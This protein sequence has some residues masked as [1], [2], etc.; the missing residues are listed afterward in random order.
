MSAP[1]VAALVLSYNGREVTLEALASLTRMDYPAYDVW[2]VDN[3]S[4]DGTAAAVAAAFPALRQLRIARNRGPA[5]G[6]AV[7]MHAA[8]AAG[9]DYVLVLNN[10]IEVAPDLLTEM[11]AA[12]E[13]EP[14]VG[15]VGPK[16]YYYWERETIWSAGG[17]LRFAEAITSEVGQGEIDRGQYDADAE[18]AY[19]NGCAML[20]KR[21]VVEAVGLWD[22]LFELCI[23]DA[24]FCLRARRAGFRCLYAHRARLWH[25][26]SSST[27]GYKP[28]KTFH[29]GRST[30]LFVRR[31][32][33]ALERLRAFAF[34]LLALPLAF[35]RELPRGN[36]RAVTAKARGFLA[37]L[38][39]KLTEPPRWPGWQGADEGV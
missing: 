2:L 11:V 6:V 17:K 1:R 15:I 38:R 30:M 33:G 18:R 9:Y 10:D 16:S 5:H 13:R 22:P 27:G 26:V 8:M 31:Y 29:S 35:L 7:G 3:G 32:A 21:R 14:S 4:T 34:M 37:G 19:I 25:M 12:A 28:G 39:V 23:E 24:D 20:I 36:A